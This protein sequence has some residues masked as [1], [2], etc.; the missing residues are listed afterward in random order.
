MC[1]EME[2]LL[3]FIPGIL[4]KKL[5]TTASTIQI[6]KL[7]HWLRKHLQNL[8]ICGKKDERSNFNIFV[9]AQGEHNQVL[10]EHL[11][12]AIYE[13]LFIGHCKLAKESKVPTFPI[14]FKMNS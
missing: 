9:N 5:K 2:I 1:M 7:R 11:V 4:S 3:V 13:E 10:R 6:L 14:A 12:D 8:A